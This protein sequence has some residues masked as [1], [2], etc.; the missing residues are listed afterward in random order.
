MPA[1]SASHN[2]LCIII[3]NTA[4]RNDRATA[5]NAHTTRT[6]TLRGVGVGPGFETIRQENYGMSD[7]I[8]GSVVLKLFETL[9]SCTIRF[10]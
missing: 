6:S 1:A 9:V 4:T 10:G 3:T 5:L 2:I 7:W 8:F